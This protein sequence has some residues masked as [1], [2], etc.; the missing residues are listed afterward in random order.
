MVERKSNHWYCNYR[1]FSLVRLRNWFPAK[2]QEQMRN[3]M[4]FPFDLNLPCGFPGVFLDE[5]WPHCNVRTALPPISIYKAQLWEPGESKE[6][7]TPLSN[8]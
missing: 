5:L 6:E 3:Y 1:I 8:G 2:G 7:G 4:E